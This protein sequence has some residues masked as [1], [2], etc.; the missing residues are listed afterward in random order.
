MGSGLYLKYTK[1]PVKKL[2]ADLAIG[3]LLSSAICLIVALSYQLEFK[4]D[5]FRLL[6]YWFFF[7]AATFAIVGNVGYFVRVLK[8]N[9]K[10]SGAPIAHLGFGMIMLGAF[11]STSQSDVIS[12]N[13]SHFDLEKA[14]DN[15]IKN[16]ENIF[17]SKGDTLPL[18]GYYVT[19]NNTFQ[20]GPDIHF[21]VD[22]LRKN[23]DSS[24]EKEF[25]LSPFIQINEKMG[26]VAE[27][28]T[29]H[30]LHKDIYTHLQAYKVAEKNYF[31]LPKGDTMHINN[32]FIWFKDVQLAVKHQ[33]NKDSGKVE[34][35]KVGAV[36]ETYFPGKAKEQFVVVQSLEG[37]QTS[38]PET[39]VESL[40]SK[41]KLVEINHEEGYFLSEITNY[42][43]EYIILKAI[44]FPLINILWTGCI[45]MIIGTTIAIVH[46]TKKSKKQEDAG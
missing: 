28:A 21:D 37:K 4:N 12:E 3:F 31:K 6:T 25:T 7:F 14:S 30:F 35:I 19:Y 44:Q 20:D 22:Y 1:T 2:L 18:G 5:T 36:F 27:P 16:N 23:P 33:N 26:N 41:L 32:G 45:V 11:I 8:G 29:K 13:T 34:S 38:S 39:K 42:S 17:L 24:F 15:S 46:R 40:K 9:L 43:S 10:S